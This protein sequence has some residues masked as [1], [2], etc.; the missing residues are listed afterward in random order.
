MSIIRQ[1]LHNAID[2]LDEND[3]GALYA[4]ISKMLAAYDPDYI[5]ATPEEEARIQQGREDIKNGDFITLEDYLN[6]P[7]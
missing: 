7:R 6:T 5:Y 3:V 2:I 4:I 1:N